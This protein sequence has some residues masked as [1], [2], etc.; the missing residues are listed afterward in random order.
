MEKDV[1]LFLENCV[2][3]AMENVDQ[4]LKVVQFCRIIFYLD[5]QNFEVDLKFEPQDNNVEGP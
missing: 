1:G 2:L 3:L 4:N 5:R